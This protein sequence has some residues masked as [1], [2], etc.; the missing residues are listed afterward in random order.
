MVFGLQI[1]LQLRTK[2]L[3]QF[4]VIRFSVKITEFIS[5][6]NFFPVLLCHYFTDEVLRTV[7][8]QNVDG[9]LR[10]RICF[11]RTTGI[12]KLTH[13]RH[14]SLPNGEA[15]VIH[16]HAYRR[17]L[18]LVLGVNQFNRCACLAVNR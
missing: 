1:I 5:G 15:A 6:M 2:F 9:S 14:S 12:F 13:F 17:K 18:R 8:S 7:F 16:P 11:T 10:V 4:P 3:L